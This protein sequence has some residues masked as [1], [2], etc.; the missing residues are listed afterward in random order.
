LGWRHSD[1][2]TYETP[3]S[4]E[5]NN[6]KRY[7]P[8]KTIDN[9]PQVIYQKYRN[10]LTSCLSETTF[11]GRCGQYQYYDM[12]QVI[13]NSLNISNDFLKEQ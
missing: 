7:Y 5:E 12:H 1:K 8:V 13:A 3:C 4:Y 6:N 10:L 9:N 2:F 11:I